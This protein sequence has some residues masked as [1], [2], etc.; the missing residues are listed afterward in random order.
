MVRMVLHQHLLVCQINLL[1]R[2]VRPMDA[3]PR[4]QL[5]QAKNLVR[6]LARH[7]RAIAEDIVV[8][9][10]LLLLLLLLLL[11]L[12]GVLEEVFKVLIKVVIVGIPVRL[13]TFSVES[14]NLRVSIGVIIHFHIAPANARDV[15]PHHSSSISPLVVCASRDTLRASLP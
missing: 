10:A 3:T 6:F 13:S 1:L 8:A 7:T 9:P 12:I 15:A 14:P 4:Q 11:V 2:R 5:L